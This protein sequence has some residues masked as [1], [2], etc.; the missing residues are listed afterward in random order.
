MITCMVF[1]VKVNIMAI[2][3][4]G[5]GGGGS[6]M[7][8]WF[9]SQNNY[10]QWATNTILHTKYMTHVHTCP[11]TKLHRDIVRCR[12]PYIKESVQCKCNN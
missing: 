3:G 9:I 7:D 8:G 4:G 5:G 10:Y 12:T 2:G 6:A 1:T 11:F